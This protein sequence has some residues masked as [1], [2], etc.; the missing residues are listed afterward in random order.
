M[1][2]QFDWA[3]R[4]T[5]Y[6]DGGATYP[7]YDSSGYRSK[8]WRPQ[9]LIAPRMAAVD[10]SLSCDMPM[11]STDTFTSTPAPVPRTYRG[12]G[13][14][15][16]D[17]V[18]AVAVSGYEEVGLRLLNKD[19]QADNAQITEAP[20]VESAPLVA[21]LVIETEAAL[22]D[23]PTHPT[24][25][26]EAIAFDLSDD[27]VDRMMREVVALV[28]TTL[29]SLKQA[30][31]AKVSVV[32]PKSVADS[33]AEPAPQTDA[34]LVRSRRFRDMPPPLMPHGLDGT[35]VFVFF[36]PDT[37]ALAPSALRLLDRIGAHITSRPYRR[38]NVLGYTDL[39]GDAAL[40]QALSTAMAV[41]V[42]DA[43]AERGVAPARI[44]MQGCGATNFWVPPADD[45]QEAR[46]RRVE[47]IISR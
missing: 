35:R 34:P 41:H 37:A 40:N 5:H 30:D 11:A 6:P 44:V 1:T 23:A 8:K 47:I 45:V 43:L 20:P 21:P 32:A 7:R 4:A 28:G 46:N 18:A 25:T 42:C 33:F 15:R 26:P 39:H 12:Y 16:G 10:Y 38:I 3:W 19:G 31:G 17:Y 9:R 2:G 29:A 24:S 36:P 27:T 14:S 13:Q 22:P